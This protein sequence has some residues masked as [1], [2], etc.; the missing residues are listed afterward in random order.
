MG[1]GTNRA[2]EFNRAGSA[3]RLVDAAVRAFGAD[4]EL[5]DH[6]TEQARTILGTE[7][8]LAIVELGKT[9]ELPEIGTPGFEEFIELADAGDVEI[10]TVVL[11]RNHQ[12]LPVGDG[13]QWVDDGTD[14][15]HDQCPSEPE[16]TA[17]P[18][19]LKDELTAMGL[20][21]TSP[22]PPP[23]AAAASVPAPRRA[24][25]PPAEVPWQPPGRQAADPPPRLA[26]EIIPT[27]LHGQNPRTHF[28]R[29]WWDATRK[30]AYAAAGYRC[31]ICGGRGTR[32]PVEL[33][34]RYSYDE[35]AR[36]PVQHV[37]GLIVLCPDCHA[38]KHLYRTS[39]VARERKD[40]AILEDALRHLRE[41]NAWTEQQ[42]DRYLTQVRR[43]YERR[44]ALGPW[45]A[46]Y[47]ALSGRKP[48]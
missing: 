6:L 20:L 37:T 9:G 23:P 17:A 5:S 7:T 22:P 33:H 34:E 28:G 11:V 3:L 40:P 39:A 41:V 48:G 10:A 26:V 12:W 30:A 38:V 13:Y 27:S 8:M 42:L 46:D 31:E 15:R 16:A 2:R 32:H 45:T 4:R 47:S 25:T 35:H 24:V 21:G 29:Q 18:V 43:T 14:R 1:N 44:E 19:S 36:P